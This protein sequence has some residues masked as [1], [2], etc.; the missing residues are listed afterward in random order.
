MYEPSNIESLPL[1]IRQQ[2]QFYLDELMSTGQIAQVIAIE[3]LILEREPGT[4]NLHIT[5]P[6]RYQAV[7]VIEATISFDFD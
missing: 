6:P 4:N 2:I 1:A 7:Q 3:D 5:L